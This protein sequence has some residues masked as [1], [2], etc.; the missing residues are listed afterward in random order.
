LD[1]VNVDYGVSG[2]ES[3]SNSSSSIRNDVIAEIA[4]LK[5][6]VPEQKCIQTENQVVAPN[7]YSFF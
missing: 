6:S 4:R 2:G 5:E 1:K 7:S 3:S